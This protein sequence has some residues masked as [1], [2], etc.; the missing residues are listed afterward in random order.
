[1]LNSGGALLKLLLGIW[2]WKFGVLPL[3]PAPCRLCSGARVGSAG[4]L[5]TTDDREAA[6]TGLG[7]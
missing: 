3:S 1:M 4:A 2:T 6:C 5:I 7:E